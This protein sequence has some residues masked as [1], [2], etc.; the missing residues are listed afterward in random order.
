MMETGQQREGA[1]SSD[2][3]ELL[4]KGTAPPTRVAV[5]GTTKCQRRLSEAKG[6]PK[7]GIC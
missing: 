1:P 6:L 2:G 4:D 3:T 5:F 7:S